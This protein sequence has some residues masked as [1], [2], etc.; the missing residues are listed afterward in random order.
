MLL[1]TYLIV[2]PMVHLS[3]GVMVQARDYQKNLRNW[4]LALSVGMSSL[5]WVAQ[6]FQ[7]QW[8]PLG[9]YWS[10]R[11]YLAINALNSWFIIE[12]LG[13]FLAPDS[14]LKKKA[15]SENKII[16][17]WRALAA[18]TVLCVFVP[19]INM[20]QLNEAKGTPQLFVTPYLSI[21][22]LLPSIYAMLLLE[23]KFRYAEEYQRK[24]ARL[25]LMGILVLTVFN[26]IFYGRS[27]LFLQV[28]SNYWDSAS[29]VFGM[30]FPV[31]LL[32]LLRYRLG[33]ERV[34][35][36]RDAVYTSVTLFLIGASF[37]GVALTVFFFKWAK[38]GFDHFENFLFVFT[39]CGL[40]VLVLGSGNMRKRIARYVNENFYLRKY[41][42]RQQFFQLHKTL[43]TGRDVG[44]AIVDLVENMKYTVTAD[45]AYVYLMDE[46]EGS[47]KWYQ[48]K[49]EQAVKIAQI[50]ARDPLIKILEEE[51]FSLDKYK[52]P[53]NILWEKDSGSVLHEMNV[54]AVFP[55][56]NQ[57]MLLGLLCLT[58]GRSKAYDKEDMDLI[59]VFSNTMGNVLFKNK[60][61]QER[62]QQKQFESFNHLAS[63]IIHDI[64][65]QVATLSLLVK[66]AEKNISNPSFQ[67]SMLKSIKSCSENLES[68]IAKLSV[69]P[70]KQHLHGE[71]SDLKNLVESAL[72]KSNVAKLS[73]V[74]VEENLEAGLELI[75]DQKILFFIITNLIRNALEAMQNQGK[76]VVRSGRVEN[77]SE[78]FY[79][80]YGRG[81]MFLKP[82]SCFVQIEDNGPGMDSKFIR[83]KLFRPFSTT[84]EKGV[85]IGLYQ[86]KVQIEKMG[87][88]ILCSSRLGE[89]TSFCLLLPEGEMGY[90]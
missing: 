9:I 45:D 28:S 42:Y 89:G 85:G 26:I 17:V 84:K 25:C 24:I 14:S 38:L 29:I 6:I 52:V 73:Q 8:D 46:S 74:Q 27:L 34:S 66:N 16:W 50:E 59:E 43:M 81:E 65:N 2:I 87:G 63:F 10:A 78:E 12:F 51:S 77:F 19:Q 76:I 53:A 54:D 20:L 67:E 86:C 3:L 35:I 31:M 55:I 79:Q 41:D 83:D 33:S 64:K 88:R 18:I 21:M 40:A 36:P 80:I 22:E 70:K 7:N 48:N 44:F 32:G 47:Y 15:G 69:G 82:F 72:E 58:G 23:N 57:N 13:V 68:L 37:L 62:I 60:V 1:L 30:G 4:V 71:K 39:L 90:N 11:I 75:A 61:M 5:I 49:E 56:K